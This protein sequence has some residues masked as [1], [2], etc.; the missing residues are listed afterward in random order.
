M[1]SRWADY[2]L[3]EKFSQFWTKRLGNPRP[4]PRP[5]RSNPLQ[6]FAS[7]RRIDSASLRSPSPFMK[8]MFFSGLPRPE[9]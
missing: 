9:F 5:F 1:N 7:L 3:T 6:G 8:R 4:L 2:F